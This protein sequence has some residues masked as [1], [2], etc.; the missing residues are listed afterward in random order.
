ML[1]GIVL[2]AAYSAFQGIMQS[3]VRLGSVISIQDNLFYFNEKLAT[4]IRSGG[5]VDYE[6]YFNRRMLGYERGFVK[7]A[8]EE[9]WTYKDISQYGNGG[10]S[11]FQCGVTATDDSD[12]CLARNA[13]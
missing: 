1:S 6:E 12:A 13:V 10:E 4:L 3:Q 2:T 5:T 8:E 7:E 11:M 9:V